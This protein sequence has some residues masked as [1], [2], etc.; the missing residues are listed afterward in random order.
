MASGAVYH[1]LVGIL[2]CTLVSLLFAGSPLPQRTLQTTI[3]DDAVLLHGSDSSVKS[4][5]SQIAHLGFN[6]VRLTASWSAI[7]PQSASPQMPGPPF[8][9]TDSL[10]YPNGAFQNLDR[11][12][13]D[14]HEA[15]LKVMI[16]VAF[17]APRWAVPIGSPG[18]Q[19]RYEPNPTQFGDF[20]KAVANRYDGGYTDPADPQVH[21]PA[22]QLYTV[23]NEPNQSEFL[24]PQW[25]QTSTGW[26]AES[27]QIYRGMYDDAYAQIKSVDPADK[28]LIGATAADG[29]TV[30][31]HG[32]V[33]PIEF[34]KGL[35][36][37]DEYLRPLSI[38]QCD[39]Y[40]PLR[41]DG[42][43]DH[44]YSLDTTPG[45]SS[46]DPDDVPLADTSR[47]ETLLNELY[48][49]GR[50][51][52][53]LPLYD[54]EYGY[55]SDPPDQSAPYSPAQQAQFVGWSTYLAWRDPGTAMFGQ[56]LLRDPAPG[57]GQSGTSPYET[58]LYY[59]DGQPKPAAQAFR[60]TLWAQRLLGPGS[61]LVL[62]FGKVPAGSGG[63]QI[64]QVESLS[65]SGTTWDPVQT[66]LPSCAS[67]AEFLTNK[68]G[69]F[70]TTAPLLGSTA[71]YR[72]G[73]RDPQ[74]QWEY[75]VP[76]PVD[77]SKPALDLA[78]NLQPASIAGS[79]PQIQPVSRS[80]RP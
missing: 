12:V 49:T 62:L 7:A 45:T 17:W 40:Q 54:T 24:E 43:A 71:T 79:G 29:S 70:L 9:P 61:P 15:G 28:V 10:T 36:C 33:P 8:D 11:A 80:P 60:V 14:A 53:D 13:L 68:A 47:L 26:V 4:A 25:Q 57:S 32:N 69:Y 35:A 21:L 23:W 20:A 65:P 76:I 46:T 41:A 37:V 74:G 30:P 6:Y 39:G 18:G 64:V 3:Q 34:V 50:I 22:V 56:F 5:I 48:L 63:R 42:F 77:A 58:G 31:G 19:N 59:A 75:G 27:P 44:P 73:W 55:D 67:E 52:T 66:L 38:P 1:P 78:P 2:A 51:T 72:L 16:D